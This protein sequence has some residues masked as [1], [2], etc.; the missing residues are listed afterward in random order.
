M[1]NAFLKAAAAIALGA[2][3]C[4]GVAAAELKVGFLNTER[5]LRE[6]APAVRAQ[7]KLEREFEKRSADLAKIQ[8]QIGDLQ[9]ILDRDGATMA[10]ADRNNKVRELSNMQRDFQRNERSFREDVNQRK[11]EEL[12]SLQERANKIIQQIAEAEKF[13]LILQ[14]PIVWASPRIDITDRIIKLLADK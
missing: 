11:N 10:E 5:V 7:K 3:A 8:K 9:A 1:V 14:E 13:D 2:L 4:T 12:A 6:S